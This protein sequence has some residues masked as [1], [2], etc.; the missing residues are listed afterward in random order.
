MHRLRPR[1]ALLAAVT[2]LTIAGARAQSAS[3]QSSAADPSQDFERARDA[4]TRAQYG[5]VV[6]ILEPLVTGE[7]PAIRDDILLQ[8]SRKY[9]GA[10]YVLTDQVSDGRAQFAALLRSQGVE[11]AAYRLE[12]MARFPSRVHEVFRGVQDELVAAA[13]QLERERQALDTAMNLRRLNAMTAL[14]AR[15]QRDEVEVHHEPAVAF[16]PFGAGQ[17]QNGNEGLGYAFLILETAFLSTAAISMGAWIPLDAQH[18]ATLRGEV[19]SEIDLGLLNA[20]IVVN[21]SSI[22]AFLATYAIGVIE[23]S[24]NFVPSHRVSRE[25]ELPQEILDNLDIAVGPGSISLRGRF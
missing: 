9:L 7:I 15:A 14:V 5:E 19:A 25:R 24:V 1:L 16:I 6:D 21:W 3:A 20:L 23:A 18:A 2:L 4:Y 10:A 22:G 17:F 11:V 8:E 13:E 12:P